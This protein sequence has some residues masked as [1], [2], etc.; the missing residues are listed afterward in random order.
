MPLLEMPNVSFYSLQKINGLQELNELPLG[1]FHNFGD[2]FDNEHGRF[3]DTAA[4]MK[5]L[6]L[7]ISIDTSVVHL[8]GAMGV[9]V[10]A[11]L[12]H[13]SCWR[14]FY[15]ESQSTLYPSMR[16]FRQPKFNDW[17]SVVLAIKKQL[18]QLV[19]PK[20]IYNE[21]QSNDQLSL[22]LELN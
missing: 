1:L 22:S 11:M 16:L 9:P 13:A 2:A 4:L 3:M 10:W 14:W 5:T 15:D 21:L 12:P 18:E 17:E 20:P 8:A 6:D 7:V 19:T